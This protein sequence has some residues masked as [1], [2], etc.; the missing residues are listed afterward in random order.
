MSLRSLFFSLFF[1]LALTFNFSAQASVPHSISPNDVIY[2]EDNRHDYYDASEFWRE[3]ADSTVALLEA[4]WLS[5]PQKGL[6][7]IL[8]ENYG[9]AL[10]LCQSEPFREQQKAAF[11]SWSL[12][13][14]DVVMTAG[15]C[16]RNQNDCDQTRFVF[17]FAIKQKGVEPTQIPTSEIYSCQSV[18]K[19]VEEDTGTDFS[20]VYLDRPVFNHRPLELA[21]QSTPQVDDPVLVIGYPSGLP[22]KIAGDAN[23]R[24]VNPKFFVAN[25]DTYVNNSGSAVFSRET[26]DIV[27]VLVRGEEDFVLQNGCNV[28]NICTDTGCRGENVTRIEQI[29]PFLPNKNNSLPNKNNSHK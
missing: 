19:W 18:I 7:Q 8:G 9:Q 1:N 11:C 2:G 28:S 4:S 23:V 27:G 29:I 17:G 25:L 6:T 22:V 5:T 16:I 3:R 24:S 10:N 21:N 13:A 15:H 14:P 12:V 26:G 20:L